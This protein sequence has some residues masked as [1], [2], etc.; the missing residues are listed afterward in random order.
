MSESMHEECG[1]CAVY[2]N[3]EAANLTYLGL[4][5]LQHRGQESAGIVSSTGRAMYR[6]VGM[7]L[8]ADVFSK[9]ALKNLRG[10]FAMGHVRYSTAGDS[11]LTN[12]QPLFVTTSRGVIAI[13]HNGTIT[14]ADRL[15]KELE[16]EGA[17]FQTTADSEVILHLIARSK[18]QSL[19]DALAE[20][21]N[22]LEGAY[23]LLLATKNELVAIRDPFGVRPLVM[24]RLGKAIVFASETSAFDLIN[25]RYE[26]EVKQGEMIWVDNKKLRSYSFA[27]AQHPK[28]CIFEYI[29][30][31]RPDSLV[32]GKSV[33]L[34]RRAMG[35]QLAKEANVDVDFVMPVPDSAT[36][37]AIG[38]AEHSEVPYEMGFIRSHYVG[39]TFIEPDQAI[40]DFG[41]KIK[42]NPIKEVLRGKRIALIDDSIVRGTTSRKLVRMLRA[43]GVKEIHLCISS[44]PITHS[45]YYGI[46]TPT[47]AELIAHKNS[48][49]RI[50]KYLKVDSLHYLSLQ[51]LIT[52][53]GMPKDRF[54]LA[55]FTGSYPMAC[56]AGC[57]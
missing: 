13:A 31:S 8:V 5:A 43:A 3:Q 42:Y 7:G 56:D 1:L 9:A 16:N 27:P 22:R 52:A 30:F 24:G 54:C 38:F 19:K 26:R 53:T 35:R 45:C 10:N 6:H 4:Y 18:R 48:V 25:V 41:A 2:G 55:C 49:S 44:P 47:R 37:A 40:R 29:Y 23:A 39:R 12:A 46:D 33:Y 11:S 14:N 32:F 20:A 50:K 36:V 34:V 51:G 15:R 28:H 21:L 57:L 17:I